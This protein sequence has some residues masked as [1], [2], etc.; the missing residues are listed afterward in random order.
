M[1]CSEISETLLDHETNYTYNIYFTDDTYLS[2][3]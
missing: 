2:S 3:D 1:K